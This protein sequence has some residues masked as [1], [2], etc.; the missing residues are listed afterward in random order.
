MAWLIYHFFSGLLMTQSHQSPTVVQFRNQQVGPDNFTCHATDG[1]D[2]VQKLNQNHLK[3]SA[4]VCDPV[5]KL[6]PILKS[7]MSIAVIVHLYHTR[8]YN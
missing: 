8:T 3:K 5:R 1:S 4:L 6:E 2:S 7:C